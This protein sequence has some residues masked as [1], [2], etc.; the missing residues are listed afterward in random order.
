V[1]GHLVELTR[2]NV[3]LVSLS[4]KAST[5]SFASAKTQAVV[6]KPSRG[7]LEKDTRNAHLIAASFAFS[8]VASAST[9]L[10]VSI[11]V[12]PAGEV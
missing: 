5:R 10:G 12:A 2:A 3:A 4:A 6:G 9:R 7:Y 11:G 1:R 8:S